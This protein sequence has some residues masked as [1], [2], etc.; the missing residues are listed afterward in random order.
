M[1]HIIDMPLVPPAD[2][3]VRDGSN[4]V[5]ADMV[6]DVLRADINHSYAKL[7]IQATVTLVTIGFS[8]TMLATHT[9]LEGVYLPIIT[10]VLGSWLPS[11]AFNVKRK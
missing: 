11:P 1:S 9:G 5:P 4:A 2:P 6:D 3:F 7:A 8:A 10:A